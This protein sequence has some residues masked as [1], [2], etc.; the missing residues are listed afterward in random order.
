MESKHSTELKQ[1]T[2]DEKAKQ[3]FLKIFQSN[4]LRLQAL[5]KETVFKYNGPEELP[6]T[7][8]WICSNY[9]NQ[10]TCLVPRSY[11]IYVETCWNSAAFQAGEL[12]INLP[13]F[14]IIQ[15]A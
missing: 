5:D 9:E 15:L 3:V 14:D 2:M 7:A 8:A 12:N 11:C 1:N 10:V 13:R 6:S 4:C